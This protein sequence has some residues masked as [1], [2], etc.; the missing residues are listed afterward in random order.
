MLFLY[1]QP[2][3][4]KAAKAKGKAKG[5]AVKANG[6]TAAGDEAQTVS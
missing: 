1:F 2:S 6:I 3:G 5:A 4:T